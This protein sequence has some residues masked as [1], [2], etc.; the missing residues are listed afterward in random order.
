MDERFSELAGTSAPVIGVEEFELATE[1]LR[2]DGPSEWV[3]VDVAQRIVHHLR[4]QGVNAVVVARGENHGIERRI[5][6]R[7]A[8]LDGGSKAM[9]VTIGLGTGGS[10]LGV[11]STLV[12]AAETVI[13]ATTTERRSGIRVSSFEN[14]ERCS[15]TVGADI[16]REFAGTKKR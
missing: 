2:Y 5:R 1:A 8:R 11:E 13:A 12:D 16:A 14:I 10:V 9:R 15:D 6:G 4:R 7:I 3:G